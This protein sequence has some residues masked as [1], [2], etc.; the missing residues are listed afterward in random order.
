MTS[1]MSEQLQIYSSFFS[2]VPMKPSSRLMYSFSLASTTVAA[3]MVSKFFI[4]VRRGWSLPYFSRMNSNHLQVTSTILASSRSI[5]ASSSRMRAIS[6]SALSL[7][8]FRMRA[9]FISMRR[10]MSSLVTSRTILGYHGVRRS[11]IHSQASSMVLA[12]SNF[13]SL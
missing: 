10:R 12:F 6:S 5:C 7:L 9:I 8:N 13:L 4:S 1:S 2:D 11:S 3:E